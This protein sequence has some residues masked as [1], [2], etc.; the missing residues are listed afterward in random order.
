M[1]GTLIVWG[2]TLALLGT[3]PR[4]PLI[5]FA[6]VAVV[7]G[8]MAA[9]MMLMNRPGP[10][11]QAAP[12]N[13]TTPTAVRFLERLP[14][15]LKGG[16]LYAIQAEDHYL[17]LHTSKG[18]DLILMR[19]ADAIVELDGIEGAQVH[20]SWWVARSAVDTVKR[21]GRRVALLLK[22]GT[23]APVSR[24]NVAALRESGWI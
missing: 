17:R 9:I 4:S 13:A 12:P 1:P 14:A 8:A 16:T 2:Y 19:I 10:A 22:D 18:S 3:A 20:R 7:T 6:E 11:T 5:L 15:K 23:E 21:D 24:P